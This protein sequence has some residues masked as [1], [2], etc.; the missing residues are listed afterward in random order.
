MFLLG[1]QSKY[2]SITLLVLLMVTQA[3]PILA[4]LAFS[5]NRDFISNELC[6]NRFEPELECNGQC[7][8]MKSVERAQ[9][10]SNSDSDV[11]HAHNQAHLFFSNFWNFT[12]SILQPVQLANFPS[13]SHY[14]LSYS[15]SFSPPPE[16]V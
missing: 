1:K 10:T 13:S 4:L 6:I 8:L 3:G 15:Y 9:D 11:G 2:F 16:L 14:C 5:E 12:P 7:Q